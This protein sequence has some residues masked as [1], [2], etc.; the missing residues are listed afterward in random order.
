MRDEAS[1]LVARV[2]REGCRRRSKEKSLGRNRSNRPRIRR[3]AGRQHSH[4]NKTRRRYNRRSQRNRRRSPSKWKLETQVE[5]L[6]AKT[7]LRMTARFPL[8]RWNAIGG[9][10]SAQLRASTRRFLQGE[11]SGGEVFQNG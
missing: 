2:S 4:R 6:R 5:I 7:T 9:P 1:R 8:S 3:R 11:V 10:S